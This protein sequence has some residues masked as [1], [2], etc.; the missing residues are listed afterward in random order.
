MTTRASRLEDSTSGFCC[1]SRWCRSDDRFPLVLLGDGMDPC[2]RGFLVSA[3][4]KSTPAKMTGMVIRQIILQRERGRGK[5]SRLDSVPPQQ[6]PSWG[7]CDRGQ[8]AP[9]RF[10]FRSRAATRWC[11]SSFVVQP[12]RHHF[13][14]DSVTGASIRQRL[15]VITSICFPLGYATLPKINNEPPSKNTFKHP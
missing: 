4:M 2:G 14:R 1:S 9:Q 5:D 8:G 3:V 6:T 13:Q 11:C 12:C 7:R 10:Q 15:C